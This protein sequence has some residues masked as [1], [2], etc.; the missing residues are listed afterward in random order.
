MYKRQVEFNAPEL[1]FGN[2]LDGSPNPPELSILTNGGTVPLE[3]SSL[4]IVGTNASDFSQSNNCPTSPQMLAA[5]ANC[6]I[7]VTF[8][9]SLAGAESA[10]ISFTDNAA[11]SPQ[12]VNLAGTGE[13][14]VASPS[15]QM[16]SF[17]NQPEGT[18]SA[19]HVVTLSNTGNLALNISLVTMGGADAAQFAIKGE[20]TCTNPAM[21]QPGANCSIGIAFAPQSTGNFNAQLQFTDNAGNAASASQIIS[22]SGA[23]VPPSAAVNL[24]PTSLIFSSQIVGTT[25]GPQT[26]TL[27]NTGSLTLQISTIS[28]TGTNASEFAFGPGT[29]CP[30]GGGAI[31]VSAQFSIKMCI[32]DRARTPRAV[33]GSI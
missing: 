33:L 18:T 26:V 7:T 10:A 12:G 5:G 28:L 21:V 8:S 17:G 20:D 19:Q 15:P 14:P 11:N 13:E 31:A 2:Q 24:A 1:N 32:R 25:S 4:G 23:G 3:I 22:L 30:L 9:P 27:A 16:V 6:S 29:G